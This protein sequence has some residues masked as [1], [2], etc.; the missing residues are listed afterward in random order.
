MKQQRRCREELSMEEEEYEEDGSECEYPL[1]AHKTLSPS[2]IN[3][4]FRLLTQVYVAAYVYI[5]VFGKREIVP[6][7]ERCA[8]LCL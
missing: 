4:L 8:G 3:L 1:R 5:R 2:L 7:C 6:L